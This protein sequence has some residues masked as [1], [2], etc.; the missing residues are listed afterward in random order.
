MTPLLPFHNTYR[1]T[2]EL[3]SDAAPELVL[4]HGWGLHSIVWDDVMPAL[5]ENFQVTVID[6]PGMGQSPL[7]NADYTLDFLVE[8]VA[9]VIPEK[10]HLIGWSLG[11][12]VALALADKMPERVLSLITVACTPKYVSDDSW[13]TA[14][15]PEI[16]DKF[17]ELYEEDNDGTLIRFLALNAKGSDTMQDDVRKLKDI[18]Y[19]CGLPAPRAL[20]EGLRILRETDLRNALRSVRVPVLMVFG[21]KDHIVPV[22]VMGAIEAMIASKKDNAL[23]RTAMMQGVSHVPFVTAPDIFVQAVNDFWR[24]SGVLT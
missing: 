22:A 6:L 1:C 11:G 10:C 4:L 23:V 17:A 16:L 21:E 5:L 8:K 3:L 19:F 24:E 12:L 15:A 18:L 14:M 2:S 20:R 7:P 13:P 9:S